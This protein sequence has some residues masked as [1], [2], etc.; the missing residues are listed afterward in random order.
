MLQ[1]AQTNQ[2][3][4]ICK[5]SDK[6]QKITPD[7]EGWRK[8]YYINLIWHIFTVSAVQAAQTNLGL[9]FKMSD[10]RLSVYGWQC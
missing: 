6:R 10:E 5:M 9:L 7:N 2:D 1:G 4:V 3:F 8:E